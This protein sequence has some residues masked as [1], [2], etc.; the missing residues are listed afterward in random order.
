MDKSSF[1]IIYRNNKNSLKITKGDK[2]KDRQYNDQKNRKAMFNNKLQRKL[3]NEQHQSH[4]M[5]VNLS[6]P[7]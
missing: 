4:K 7:D 1:T 5:R 3:K 6:V 2:S